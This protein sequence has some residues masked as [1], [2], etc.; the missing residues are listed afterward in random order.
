LGRRLCDEPAAD[1]ALTRA[2]AADVRRRRFETPGIL[3]RRH[4]DQPLLDHSASQRVVVSECLKGRERDFCAVGSHAWTANLHVPS[5][6]DHLAR[7]RP[8]AGR[9]AAPLVLI[10]RTA[11]RRPIVFPHRVED[12]ETRHHGQFHQLSP[13]INQ[14]INQREMALRA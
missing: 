12:L 9:L 6:Q 2:A 11:D 8:G 13:R 1:R 4:A 10:A 3:S 5:A 14:Q 7:D